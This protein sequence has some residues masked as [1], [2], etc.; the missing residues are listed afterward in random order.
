M[1]LILTPLFVFSQKDSTHTKQKP[2]SKTT[3]FGIKAGLNFANVTNAS[4]IR[5][6]NQTGFHAGVLAN[7]GGKLISFR[8]EILYSRQ[9]YNY[10]NDSSSGSVNHDYIS[11]SE[12]VGINITKYVQLQ[13]GAQT[14]YLIN[15]SATSNSQSTGNATADK[16]LSYYNRFDYGFAGGLEIHPIAGVLIGARYDISL[17][18]LYNNTFSTSSVGNYGGYTANINFKNNVVQVFVGYRF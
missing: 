8:L 12:M 17:S 3:Y 4:S 14:G 15:A 6:G 11:L 16:I 13:I 7:I 18:S 10:S 9:G 5:A 1:L 2:K